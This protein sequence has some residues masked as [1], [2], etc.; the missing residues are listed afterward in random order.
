MR[1]VLLPGLDGTGD[2]FEPL[3]AELPGWIEPQIVRYTSEGSQNYQELIKLIRA[4][5]PIDEPYVILGWSF[6]GPLAL[7]VAA[8]YPANLC[9]VVLCS[10]FESNPHPLLGWLAPAAIAPLFK[11]VPLWSKANALLFAYSRPE[12]RRR[13]A[14]ANAK[15]TTAALAARVREVLRLKPAQ[16]AARSRV[17]LLYIAGTLDPVVPPSNARRVLKANQLAQLVTIPG[18][19]LVLLTNPAAAA[20][21]IAEFCQMCQPT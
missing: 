21:A 9:G 15:V 7:M 1:L 11:F 2:L 5:L 13:I 18:P 3:V 19:H 12:L 20:E 4:A 10:S 16:L 8:D 6:S 17:P 14:A